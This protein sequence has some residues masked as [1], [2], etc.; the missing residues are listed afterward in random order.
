MKEEILI[1]NVT[2]WLYYHRVWT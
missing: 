1:Y 2:L